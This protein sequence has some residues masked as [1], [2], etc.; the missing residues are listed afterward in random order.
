MQNYEFIRYKNRHILHHWKLYTDTEKYQWYR[1]IRWIKTL[2][3]SCLYGGHMLGYTFVNSTIS[4]KSVYIR[5]VLQNLTYRSKMSHSYIFL[6]ISMYTVG[7]YTFIEPASLCHNHGYQ[8]AMPS[9]RKFGAIPWMVLNE[10][11]DGL[12][13]ERRNVISNALVLISLSCTNPSICRLASNQHGNTTNVLTVTVI[14]DDI[15][16]ILQKMD[17]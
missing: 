9:E 4:F 11:I 10:C 16:I 7:K 5:R 17:H 13:Q 1:A 8:S 15:L 2:T 6:Y 12:V 14:L 3:I